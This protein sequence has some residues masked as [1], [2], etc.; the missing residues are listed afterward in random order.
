M[1]KFHIDKGNNPSEKY[2]NCKYICTECQHY[3]HGAACLMGRGWARVECRSEC[4][5]STLHTFM[6]NKIM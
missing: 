6:Q 2:K 1:R 3:G 5:R 4:E